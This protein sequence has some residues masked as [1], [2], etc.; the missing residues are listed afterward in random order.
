MT[1]SKQGQWQALSF[2]IS[3]HW[4]QDPFWFEGLQRDQQEM[5]I[6][7]FLLSRESKKDAEKRKIRYNRRILEKKRLKWKAKNE[8][9]KR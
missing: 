5:L 7:E 4:N 6:A 3:Q 8:G 1:F 2:R 9:F